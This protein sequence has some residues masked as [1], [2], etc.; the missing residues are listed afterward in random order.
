MDVTGSA[1]RMWFAG[2]LAAMLLIGV[3]SGLAYWWIGLPSPLALGIITGL[4]NF[5]PFIGPILGAIP[6]LIFALAI[7]V[8]TVLW[9][10]GA[11]IAIQQLEGNVVTPLI[12]RQAVLMPPALAL[13]AIVIFGLLFGLLGVF[14][15]AP[16]A[17]ALLVLVKK[18]WV[19]ETL[20]EHT[21]VPGEERAK[22]GGK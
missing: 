16:L 5:I 18:L 9:T 13:F 22:A 8:E 21:V 1:L 6:A 19:R 10:A 12:Q 4:T 15:A 2:Q 20:G 11:T 14:L 7:D 17:V 3:V